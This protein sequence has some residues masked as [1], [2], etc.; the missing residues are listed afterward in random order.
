MEQKNYII[1]IKTLLFYEVM[2]Y[3]INNERYRHYGADFNEESVLSDTLFIDSYTPYRAFCVP[4]PTLPPIV[5]NAVK[6]GM[7]S[8]GDPIHFSVKTRQKD[9]SVRRRHVGEND[10]A[11]CGLI[12]SALCG[13]VQ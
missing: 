10:Y 7:G 8:S 13:K 6:H 3:N 4:P 12:L 5:E 2:M 1:N 11:E 9:T